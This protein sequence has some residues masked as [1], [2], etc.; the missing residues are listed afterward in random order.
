MA[1]HHRQG[2]TTNPD[3]QQL[4]R[5][6]FHWA[7]WLE[8][9]GS[10]GIGDWFQVTEMNRYANVPNS[11]GWQYKQIH[12][13]DARDPAL[14][15]VGR[16]MVGKMKPSSS[17]SGGRSSY[18][19]DL[20]QVLRNLPLPKIPKSCTGNPKH[21]CVGILHGESSVTWTRAALQAMRDHGWVDD[22]DLDAMMDF[23]LDTGSR[24]FTAGEIGL[25]NYTKRKF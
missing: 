21:H 3:I 11:G 8:Q 18:G 20:D 9:K 14:A 22:F 7:I 17:S 12:G 24:W 10:K 1:L 2:V 13:A 6:R 19:H 25:A 5:A 4:G 23:A 16:I 15:M